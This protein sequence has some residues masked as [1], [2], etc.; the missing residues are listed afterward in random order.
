MV[1]FEKCRHNASPLSRRLSEPVNRRRVGRSAPRSR[2]SRS[3]VGGPR[4]KALDAQTAGP[5]LAEAHRD[6]TAVFGDLDADGDIDAIIGELGGP[7]RFLRN[8]SHTATSS[9]WLIVELRDARSTSK[10]HRALGSRVDLE[11]G[12]VRQTRWIYG[13]G[14][15]QSTSSQVA[16][17][18]LGTASESVSLRITWPDG[19][20]ERRQN[21][22]L[23]Q[24]IVIER[25]DP[26]RGDAAGE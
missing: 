17:F 25:A 22:T 12:D 2:I 21:V 15:F 16:H 10:N 14:P 11:A 23:N 1:P 3:A 13:G 5:W 26:S 24:R 9:S 18:G 4:F 7:L 19:T 20:D 6:R 8:D